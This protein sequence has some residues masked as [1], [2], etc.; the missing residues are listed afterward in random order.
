MCFC[1]SVRPSTFHIFCY[2]TKSISVIEK[3]MTELGWKNS[4]ECN[5]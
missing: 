4:K 5:W 1:P 3:I 2:L